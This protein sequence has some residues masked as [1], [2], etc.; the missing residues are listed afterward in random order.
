[1]VVQL[2]C[3][4]HFLKKQGLSFWLTATVTTC[5]LLKITINKFDKDKLTSR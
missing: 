4:L 2:F 1:M 3:Q 5:K